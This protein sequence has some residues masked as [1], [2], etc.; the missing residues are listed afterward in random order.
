MPRHA[1]LAALLVASIVASAEDAVHEPKRATLVVPLT[2]HQYAVSQ[3]CLPLSDFYRKY[4]DVPGAPY[5]YAVHDEAVYQSFVV[6]CKEP[7]SVDYTLLFNF[8]GQTGGLADCP[9]RIH[10]PI[11]IPGAISVGRA[12]TSKQLTGIALTLRGYLYVDTNEP[13]R[14]GRQPL[15]GRFIESGHWEVGMHFYCVDGRWG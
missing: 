11:L 6:W 12:E 1:L 14:K 15:T 4:P 7:E 5:A 2:I 8:Q 10:S 3:G 13:V 9:D